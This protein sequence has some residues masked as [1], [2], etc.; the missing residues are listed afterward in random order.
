MRFAKLPMPE[1]PQS[2]KELI[3]DTPNPPKEEVFAKVSRA[4]ELL[5]GM[6][7]GVSI[8]TVLCLAAVDMFGTPWAAEILIFVVGC[9]Y[10]LRAR[11]FPAVRQRVP[12]LTAGII[13][14]ALLADDAVGLFGPDLQLIGLLVVVLP[15]VIIAVGS[16]LVYSKKAPS[17][18]IGRIADIV[19]ILFIVAVV[20]VACTAMGLFGFMSGMFG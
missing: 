19:D 7:T 2:A 9:V 17:P 4:D 8:V 13:G 5:T 12:L 10:L 20:P 6:L 14:L 1:L 15:A 3:K 18:Y 11:L 16:G